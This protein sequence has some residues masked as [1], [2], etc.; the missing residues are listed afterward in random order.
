M[1]SAS[2]QWPP[3]AVVCWESMRERVRRWRQSRGGFGEV[4]LE[5]EE[6]LG[7]GLEGESGS[8]VGEGVGRCG[9]RHGLLEWRE[10]ATLKGE[11]LAG[12]GEGV[13]AEDPGGDLR[14]RGLSGKPTLPFVDG[15]LSLLRNGQ[16]NLGF[17]LG[18]EGAALREGQEGGEKEKENGERKTENGGAPNGATDGA[19][20]GEET[21][22]IHHEGPRGNTKGCQR[23]GNRR[24]RRLKPI[25]GRLPP[26][27][28]RELES[29]ATLP[30]ALFVAP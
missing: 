26:A 3:W 30:I 17:G 13:A 25:R 2:P 6:G 16:R 10:V 8:E 5:G 29:L 18:S 20:G 22:K 24:F 1:D 4:A 15:V 14:R 21:F 19:V 23:K 12:G 7:G 9:G 11:G 27:K 28:H